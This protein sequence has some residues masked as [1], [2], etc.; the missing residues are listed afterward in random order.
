MQLSLAQSVNAGHL[1]GVGL[2]PGN[3]V[4]G[5]Q[6]P[7][8]LRQRDARL[9]AGLHRRHIPPD[10]DG[11]HQRTPPPLPVP[12]FILFH[13]ANAHLRAF[14]HGVANHDGGGN[15]KDPHQTTSQSMSQYLF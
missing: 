6:Q 12:G 13:R 1:L 2:L 5:H 14:P 4:A 3:H 7:P 8:A 9:H 15:P 10:L 11:H